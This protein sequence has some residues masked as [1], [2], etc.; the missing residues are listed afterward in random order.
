MV[1]GKVLNI[2]KWTINEVL[3][4]PLR[5][6]ADV[7]TEA[8]GGPL[9]IYFRQ[10][11]PEDKS[12]F[13]PFLSHRALGQQ[14][15]GKGRIENYSADKCDISD[16]SNEDRIL[17]EMVHRTLVPTSTYVTQPTIT[18]IMLFYYLVKEV[19]IN[20]G[21]AI[22]EHIST[23]KSNKKPPRKMPY[24]SLITKIIKSKY[25]DMV[26]TSEPQP[27]KLYDKN[28]LEN[29]DWCLVDGKWIEKPPADKSKRPRSPGEEGM[30]YIGVWLN[31]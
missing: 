2:S 5:G 17:Y 21:H 11:W 16:L 9:N 8:A 25:P 6:D 4:C 22:I 23:A 27:C 26:F 19:G 30:S 18:T 13:L 31:M 12:I 28:Y 29:H 14:F 7:W 10:T 24:G 20:P 15:F 3:G 1:N